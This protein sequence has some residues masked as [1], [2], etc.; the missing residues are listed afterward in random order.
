MH[1]ART[2]SLT[3]SLLLALM[4]AS[5]MAPAQGPEH[6]DDEIERCLVEGTFLK[7][8]ETLKGVTKP[9]KVEIECDLGI[10]SAKFTAIDEHRRGI[11]RLQRGGAEMNFS[12][13]YRYERAAYLLDR[14]LGLGM[15]PVAVLRSRKGEDGALVDWI[16]DTTHGNKLPGQPT[17]QKMAE[18]ARQKKLMQ[19]FDALIEN[20]DRS[21][22]NWLIQKESWKVYLIDH[23]RAFRTDKKL[24]Q[25]FLDEPARL[26]REIYERLRELDRTGLDDLLDDLLDGNQI[27]ALNARRSELIAK[28]DSDRERLGDDAVFSH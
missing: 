17:G 6:S 12:D 1:P 3:V 7:G 9:V 20:T 2:G 19:L 28:I 13:D 15:V 25:D 16:E 14:E 27:E 4:M 18:L 10:R 24:K 21:P 8:T 26:T 11:T 22:S 23:T 5:S